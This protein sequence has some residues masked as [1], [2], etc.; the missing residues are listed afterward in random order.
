MEGAVQVPLGRQRVDDTP[1]DALDR[2][3]PKADIL[4]GYGEVGVGFV[5][6]GRQQRNPEL[7]A[8]GDILGDLGAVFKDRRQQRG[9][10]LLRIVRLHIGRTVGDD[11]IADGVR[12]VEGVARKVQDLVIDAVRHGLAH[13]VGD[14]A[15]NVPARVAVDEGLAL[16]VNDGVLFLAHRAADHVGLAEREAREALEDLDDLLLIDD[17]A[18]GDLQNWPQQRV[19][20]AD[21]LRIA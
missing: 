12:L 14:R 11:G 3:Q 15:G 21:L 16:G 5:D 20:I 7:L 9:H 17:A 13:A 18:V 8:L 6:V 19:L 10:V 2:D 4:P 1:A